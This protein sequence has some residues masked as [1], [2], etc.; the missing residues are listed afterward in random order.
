MN[1][2]DFYKKKYTKQDMD[3]LR[4]WF[5][6][7]EAEL[8]QTLELD[9]ATQLHDLKRTVASYLEVYDIHGDNPTFSGQMHHLFLIRARL[10]EMGIKD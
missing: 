7:H 5:K 4:A 9:A 8:P 6:R 1:F 10:E 3:E 2:K